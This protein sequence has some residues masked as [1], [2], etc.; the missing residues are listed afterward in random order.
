MPLLESHFKRTG[1][2]VARPSPAPHRLGKAFSV[3]YDKGTRAALTTSAGMLLASS[4][5]TEY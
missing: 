1:G 5:D 4:E 2:E 3:S